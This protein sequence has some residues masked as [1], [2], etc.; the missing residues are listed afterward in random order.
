[1]ISNLIISKC[2]NCI[3]FAGAVA[4]QVVVKSCS[5]TNITVCCSRIIFSDEEQPTF[6]LGGNTAFVST[7]GRPVVEFYAGTEQAPVNFAPCNFWYK[8]MLSDLNQTGHILSPKTNRYNQAYQISPFYLQRQ[9]SF[10]TL[11]ENGGRESVLLL[12]VD[13]FS[14]NEIPFDVLEVGD[15]R[16]EEDLPLMRSEED[17]ILRAA[18]PSPYKE[19]IEQSDALKLKVTNLFSQAL[20]KDENFMVKMKEKFNLW[21]EDANLMNNVNAMSKTDRL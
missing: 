7:L 2:K 5:K 13:Q 14:L 19:W 1:M 12:P 8:G 16:I 17:M 20:T 4:E 18:L 11:V 9:T 15:D 21:L 3:I 10:D 6:Q